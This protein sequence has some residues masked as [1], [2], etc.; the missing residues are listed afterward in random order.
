MW[1]YYKRLV[2][3]TKTLNLLDQQ[4]VDALF[5]PALQS[6]V[7]APEDLI[8]SLSECAYRSEVFLHQL[9]PLSEFY[10]SRNAP[11]SAAIWGIWNTLQ[12]ARGQ[13]GFFATVFTTRSQ[14]KKLFI[15]ARALVAT[16]AVQFSNGEA[17][18]K[19]TSGALSDLPRY[20]T[21]VAE[22]IQHLQAIS[23]GP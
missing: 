17:Q 2:E 20:K 5:K 1:K 4:V 22:T 8:W 10:Q 14:Q 11:L 12:Y 16:A 3:D 6:H 19:S 13:R 23:S 15:A 7:F 9:L 18:T 21:Y